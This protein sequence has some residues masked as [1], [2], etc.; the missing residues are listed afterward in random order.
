M[1]PKRKRR[2]ER[3]KK[4]SSFQGAGSR[5]CFSTL[6]PRQEGKEKEESR[7]GWY[8]FTSREWP[9]LL[10]T[11]PLWKQEKPSYL[12]TKTKAFGIENE[13]TLEHFTIKIS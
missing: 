7:T 8:P 12:K 9:A 4:E 5:P 2:C 1:T 13:T 11:L 3:G 6:G 10:T